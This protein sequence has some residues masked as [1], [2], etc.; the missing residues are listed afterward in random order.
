[1]S[2]YL[3]TDGHFLVSDRPIYQETNAF[4][5]PDRDRDGAQIEPF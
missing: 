5:W 1:M 2:V 3:S 4:L